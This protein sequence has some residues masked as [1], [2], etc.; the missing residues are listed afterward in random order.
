[1][2]KK[3]VLIILICVILAILCA[4]VAVL[5]KMNSISKHSLIYADRNNGSLISY[6][7]SNKAEKQIS[8]DGYTEYLLVGKYVGGDYCCVAKSENSI[9]DVL[10][11]KDGNIES[12]CQLSFCPDEITAS[13]D[14]IYCLLNDEIYLLN[15][16][17]NTESLYMENVYSDIYRLN[18][19]ITDK[20]DL[21]YKK[22]QI[23]G[24]ISVILDCNGRETSA[25]NYNPNDVIAIGLDTDNRFLYK[26]KNSDYAVMAAFVYS[27]RTQK[28]HKYGKSVTFIQTSSDGKLVVKHKRQILGECSDVYVTDAKTGISVS[29]VYVDLDIPYSAVVV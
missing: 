9:Y 27:D 7:I 4:T 21:V 12:T 23:D 8:F 20:G 1:M 29:T 10:L 2:K 22:Q 3:R 13:D 6:D 15:K 25:F 26:D 17:D 16:N 28:E 19:F 11:I 14:K 18:I 5:L 24:S